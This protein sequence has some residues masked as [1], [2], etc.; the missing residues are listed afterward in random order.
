MCLSFQP[1]CVGAYSAGS[2][3]HVKYMFSVESF[4]ED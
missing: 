2:T 3:H 1:Q 4:D